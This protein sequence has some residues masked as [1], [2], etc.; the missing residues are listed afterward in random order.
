ME[1]EVNERR[2]KFVRD[3]PE[4]LYSFNP[5]GGGRPYI[6]YAFTDRVAITDSKSSA[7]DKA[8]AYAVGI[9]EAVLAT[10]ATD[11]FKEEFGSHRVKEVRDISVV[12][13]PGIYQRNYR[14]TLMN[15][16]GHETVNDYNVSFD[17][18]WQ[19][20]TADEYNHVI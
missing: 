6:R 8:Y 9:H 11:Y 13:G 3:C 14:V 17:E 4:F 7:L 18:D 15:D 2:E 12:F 5:E 16:R 1:H 10:R 20:T 19:V